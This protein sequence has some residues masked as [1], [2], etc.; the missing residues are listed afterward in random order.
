MNDLATVAK[1]ALPGDTIKYLNNILPNGFLLVYEMPP[2]PGD[3]KAVLLM[4]SVTRTGTALEAIGTSVAH[5]M[6]NLR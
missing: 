4:A 6:N 5:M 1:C 2:D 3:N